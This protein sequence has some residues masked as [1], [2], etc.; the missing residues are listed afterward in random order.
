[1]TANHNRI[2][3]RVCGEQFEAKDVWIGG[4]NKR[5]T[6]SLLSQWI[7]INSFGRVKCFDVC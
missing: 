2:M 3:G 1:M 7:K 5:F 4:Q 6:F